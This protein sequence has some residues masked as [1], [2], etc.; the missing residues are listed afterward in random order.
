MKQQESGMFDI[1]YKRLH[2]QVANY[3][4]DTR[5]DITLHVLIR[6]YMHCKWNVL[7]VVWTI[8]YSKIYKS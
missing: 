7:V 8:S 2:K 1:T 5:K 3:E 4:K 6:I